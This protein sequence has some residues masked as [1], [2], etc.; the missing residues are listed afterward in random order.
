MLNLTVI[1]IFEK[2]SNYNGYFLAGIF[3]DFLAPETSYVI[4]KKIKRSLKREN[5]AKSNF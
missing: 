3:K 4:I 1:S 5:H 2:T